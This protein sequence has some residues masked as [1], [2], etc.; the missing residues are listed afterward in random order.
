MRI[1]GRTIRVLTATVAP[2]CSTAETPL[3]DIPACLDCL[4]CTLMAS[5]KSFEP[6]VSKFLSI[7]SQWLQVSML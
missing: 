4:G 1:N 7:I 5:I 2:V 6:Q 3:I